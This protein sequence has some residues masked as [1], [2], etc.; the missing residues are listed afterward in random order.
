MYESSINIASDKEIIFLLD[1]ITDYQTL[2]RRFGER[3]EVVVLDTNIKVLE[4]IAAHLSGRSNLQ[5]I[6]LVTHGASGAL[7]LGAL[8]LTAEELPRHAGTLARIGQALSD[9]GDMLLYGCDVAQGEEGHGF[10]VELARLTRADL[11]ASTDV[12]GAQELGGDWQLEWTS[13]L[14]ESVALDAADWQG[15][16][17]R[18]AP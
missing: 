1:D 2:A 11:A 3:A 6:H 10:L 15:T 14:V 13:G 17:K 18:P 7:Q 8:Q 12:T 4:Q 5:A 16:P 9:D